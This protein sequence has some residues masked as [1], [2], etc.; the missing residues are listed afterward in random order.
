MT[1]SIVVGQGS[2][3]ASKITST[4]T[5]S[6]VCAIAGFA[7]LLILRWKRKQN[8]PPS[9]NMGL[10][11]IGGMI[12]FLKDPL[13]LLAKGKEKHGECFQ[14]N[15]MGKQ[16]IC[17]VGEKGHEFFFT[18]DK[19]LDQAKMYSFT[20]PIFGKKVLYDV[21][22][23]KRMCQIRFIR[24]RLTPDSLKSYVETLEN[25]ILQ[26]FSEEWS[27]D[28]GVRDIRAAMIECLS[29]T[30]VSC[31]MGN[32][33][34]E[35]L[36]VEVAPG[37]SVSDLLH[38]LEYGML[39]LSVFMPSFPCPR[40]WRRD[41]ARRLLQD[42]F[43][44]V[45]AERRK[46]KDKMKGKDFL[47][48]VLTSTYPDGSSASDEEIV[49]FLIAAFFG[50]MHNSSITTSWS[51]LEIFSRPALA[52]EIMAEQATALGGLDPS[53]PFSYEAYE[54]M[55]KL[56]SAVMETLRMHPPLML[57]MRT[58]EEDVP[59]NGYKIPRGSMVA[60]SPTVAGKLPEIFP[61]P[62]VFE[63]MRF[64]EKPPNEFA[65]I[66]FGAGR[67]VCKG[68]EFG[69]LQIMATISMMMRT[70]EIE[71]LD[72]VTKPTIGEGM[73]IAPSQPCRVHFKRRSS[74][75]KGA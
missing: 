42:F 60:V 67:R 4:T 30:S 48:K 12:Q 75:L 74:C 8:E 11:I 28:E 40:H 45:L 19:Y 58:V 34:R 27:G 32:E 35:K 10:P 44:P 13:V 53:L 15:L 14:V 9:F 47:Q 31:L 39:P 7:G 23:S 5:T 62:D 52:A 57:L 41:E 61:N 2:S 54:A 26:Y 68:Q 37:R 71:T 17:L 6:L 36:N 20:I 65:Y 3:T 29:R 43:V 55:P 21:D 56:R 59:F 25:E 64:L 51:I 38:D 49:G 1:L 69:Y 70:Y 46:H 22:Y 72:G 33:L 73:V 63:P 24:E 18:M 66:G 16:M 50:G